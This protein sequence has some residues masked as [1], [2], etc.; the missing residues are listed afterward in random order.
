[1]TQIDP[2]QLTIINN[3]F[4]NI[5]REMG[6]TMTRTAFSPI[7]NEGLDFSCVLFDRNGNMIGQAEFCPAQL[8]A[9]MF[10]VRWTVEELGVESFAP[11]S[12]ARPSGRSPRTP[13]RCS[14]RGC[15]SRP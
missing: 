5:C 13:P 7:F 4:V 11:R 14:R 12:A 8:A 9:S 2:V 6:I 1:M 3:S 15:G 10:I